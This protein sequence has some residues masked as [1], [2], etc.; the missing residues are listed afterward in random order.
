VFR[1]RW[2]FGRRV[3]RSKKSIVYMGIEA[4]GF[5]WIWFFYILLNITNEHLIA[6]PGELWTV[7][8]TS[9]LRARSLLCLLSRNNWYKSN[10]V[11]SPQLWWE[12]FPLVHSHQNTV[13]NLWGLSAVWHWN[14]VLANGHE[15]MR[16]GKVKGISGFNQGQGLENI[17]LFTLERVIARVRGENINLPHGEFS[18]RSF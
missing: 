8:L 16:W 6:L 10:L 4:L 13:A 1:W 9:A 5:L 12:W 15:D 17:I 3:K 14:V 2:V 11:T 7:M 18:C